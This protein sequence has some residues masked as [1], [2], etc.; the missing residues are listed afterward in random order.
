[1]IQSK[2]REA[3]TRNLIVSELC[4]NVLKAL[5]DDTRM[6]VVRQL[7]SGPKH[8]GELNQLGVEQSLLS[9]HL[10]V[11]KNAGLVEAKRDGKAMRYQLTPRVETRSNKILN[12]G[13]CRL[14]FE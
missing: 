10:K 11:L 5:A 2:F 3:H 9:H 4:T 8:A 12:L 7:M 6:S 14:T 13:C 1:M